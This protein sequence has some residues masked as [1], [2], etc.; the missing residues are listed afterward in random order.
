[1]KKNITRTVLKANGMKERKIELD[2]E[3]YALIAQY[4]AAYVSFVISDTDAEAARC[5]STAAFLLFYLFV[6]GLTLTICFFI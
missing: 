4:S 5:L 2:Y 1:M 3:Y 6:C